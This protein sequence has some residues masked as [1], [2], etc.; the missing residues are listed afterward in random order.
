MGEAPQR[1]QTLAAALH[2]PGTAP[3]E[4]VA[5]VVVGQDNVNLLLIEEEQR[6]SV[7]CLDC[8]TCLDPVRRS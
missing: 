6:P 8:F 5:P 1:R 7:V 2:L 3:T 4:V